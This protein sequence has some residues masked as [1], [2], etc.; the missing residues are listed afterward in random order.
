[1]DEKIKIAPSILAADFSQLGTETQAITKAGAD[2]V[3]VDVMDGHFVPNITI[4]PEVIKDL[5]K[6]TEL[7]FDVHLMIAPVDPFLESF[8][9]FLSNFNISN[10]GI[11]SLQGAH[12]VA[13][14]FNSKSLPL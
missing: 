12:Q 4:G 10:D 13:Q 8:V 1:M 7:P 6:Y 11:S 14:K 9:K 2:Y 5:R 3:H